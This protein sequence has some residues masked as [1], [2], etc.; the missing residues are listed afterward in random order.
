MIRFRRTFKLLPGVKLHLGKKG[1]GISFG[2]RGFHVGIRN[3]GRKY[4]SAGLPGT[5]IYA[6]QE[7]GKK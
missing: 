2:T 6:M 1:V 7:L 3:D 5:G 4:I